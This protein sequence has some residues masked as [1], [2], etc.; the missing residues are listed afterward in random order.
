MRNEVVAAFV[1]LLVIA[2]AGV[3]YFIGSS[4]Q[5]VTASVSTTTLTATTLPASSCGP[6]GCDISTTTFEGGTALDTT[7]TTKFYYQISIN[8]SGSWN[9]AYW[10]QNGTLETG[11]Q[12]NSVYCNDCY[13]GVLQYNVYGGMTGSGNYHTELV[14]YGV[15]YVE[16]VL[17]V[18]AAILNANTGTLTLTVAV[19]TGIAT[20]AIS[21]TVEVCFTFGV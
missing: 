6:F 7:F 3:G 1:I 8:Y 4:S 13:G 5:R 17:C 21:P 12:S 2:S 9:L 10:G 20:A 19:K 18:D 14:T 11:S 16:N 15:G